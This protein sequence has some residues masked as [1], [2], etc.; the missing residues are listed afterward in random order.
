MRISPIQNVNYS[1]Y[2][3]KKIENPSFKAFVREVKKPGS[4][5]IMWKNN[6]GIFRMD[7]SWS[8]LANFLKEKY[9]DVEKVHVYNYASSNGLEAYSLLMELLANNDVE[10]VDKFLPIIAKDVD[11]YAIRM[12]KGRLVDINDCEKRKINI[13]TDNHFD[14]YFETVSWKKGKYRPKLKLTENVEFSVGDFTK[15]YEDLPKDNVIIIARNCWRYFPEDARQELP[16]KL[17]DHLGKNVTLITGNYDTVLGFKKFK[18]SGF[19][20]TH[21]PYVY[22]K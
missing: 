8:D 20:R 16:Q 14:D 18:H 22:V 11:E 9:S 21:I 15:E 17:Y 12:A 1:S 2:Q 7:M 6:T 3:K 19:K 5:E 10:D 13:H 4:D